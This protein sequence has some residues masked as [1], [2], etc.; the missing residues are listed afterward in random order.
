MKRE[1]T[2]FWTNTP[3]EVSILKILEPFFRID[4]KVWYRRRES[5]IGITFWKGDSVKGVR[6]TTELRPMDKYDLEQLANH[7]YTCCISPT[8]INIGESVWV[9][10]KNRANKYETYYRVVSEVILRKD[11]RVFAKLEDC[12]DVEFEYDKTLYCNKTLAE[13]MAKFYELSGEDVPDKRCVK[14]DNKKEVTPYV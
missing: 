7:I 14:K 11:G 2:R 4:K 12:D 10:V 6:N 13:K 5:S 3:Q 8:K 1:E 9:I